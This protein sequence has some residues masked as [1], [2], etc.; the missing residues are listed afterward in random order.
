MKRAVNHALAALLSAAAIAG[1]ASGAP[2]A[3]ESERAPARAD[4]RDA[5]SQSPS[6]RS[7]V[8]PVPL[9]P[10]PVV[11]S[12]ASSAS[13]SGARAPVIRRGQW[14][15]DDRLVSGEQL[16]DSTTITATP[17]R[18]Q[19]SAPDRA[20]DAHA[21]VFALQI[22]DEPSQWS[23]AWLVYELSGSS[24]W[25]AVRRK[26]NDG[27]EQGGFQP[28]RG[29]AGGTQVEEISPSWLTRGRNTVRF[30]PRDATDPTGRAAA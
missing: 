6:A 4:T 13:A 21:G 25:T 1:C 28:S 30:E 17:D 9:P 22:E 26:I 12:R 24:H 18:S 7:T 14:S 27:V 16:E 10:A 5:A 3:P 29:A 11:A 20:R 2:N 8:P 19:V 23:R 15:T